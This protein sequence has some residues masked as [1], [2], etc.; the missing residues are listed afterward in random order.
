MTLQQLYYFRELAHMEHYTKTAL[1]LHISQPALSY[2]I[3]ELEKE[4]GVKLF[5]RKGNRIFLNDNGRLFYS[6]IT[7]GLESIDNGI[8]AITPKCRKE[9]PL[10][11]VGYLHS[12]SNTLLPQFMDQLRIKRIHE[13][14]HLTFSQALDSILKTGLHEGDFDIIFSASPS[15]NSINFPIFKQYLFLYIPESHR[16]YK[17]ENITLDDI[18]D[19]E[20]ILVNRKSN[21][22]EQIEHIFRQMKK[23]LAVTLEANNCD[24]V[25]KYVSNGY[26]LAILP[27]TTIPSGTV[28]IREVPLAPFGFTRTIYISWTSS[29]VKKKELLTDIESIIATLHL[30]DTT[31]H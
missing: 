30:T 5:D 31:K 26:G 10:L 17:T 25:L 15:S 29:L 1:K 27:R 8:Q 2:S 6:F 18:A 19:E 23:K 13:K 9:L 22:R 16:L 14:A 20:F 12:I 7:K 11:Q 4:L 21:L 3:A 28:S 24:A